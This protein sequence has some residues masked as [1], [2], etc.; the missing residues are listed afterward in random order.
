MNK[1]TN[2]TLSGRTLY[3]DGSWNTLILPFS[4]SRSEMEA[5]PLAGATVQYVNSTSKVE[6]T[7]VTLNTS[8]YTE[9]IVAGV[10]F[11]LKWDSGDNITSPTFNN[12]LIE[13]WQDPLG[14][15]NSNYTIYYI[16]YYSADMLQ[17]E[18]ELAEDEALIYYLAADNKLKYTA[19]PRLMGA[20]RHGFI[21]RATEAGALSF[22][23]DFDGEATTGIAEADIQAKAAPEGYYNLQGVKLNSMPTQKGVYINNGKKVIIK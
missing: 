4:L 16:G 15:L 1:Q 23:L 19:K 5:S 21:F 14:P 8:T 2:V 20:F 18:S 6:G 17:P 10:P 9:G 7:H 22:T 3:K 12:V 11:F 13:E